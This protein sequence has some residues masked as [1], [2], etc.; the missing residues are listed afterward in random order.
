MASIRAVLSIA[1]TLALL[2][3]AASGLAGQSLADP[4]LPR[5]HV[6]ISA[7]GDFTS[8][9]QGYGEA[10]EGGE[11]LNSELLVPGLAGLETALSAFAGDSGP[12]GIE[13]GAQ[14]AFVSRSTVEVPLG[15]EVGIFD[16]LTV[17]A[18]L[19][20]VQTRVEAELSPGPAETGLGTNPALTNPGAVSGYLGALRDLG[21]QVEA[22][23]ESRCDADANS[24]GCQEAVAA[25]E[26]LANGRAGLRSAYGASP[27]FP[28]AGSAGAL[29]LEAW[30]ADLDAALTGLGVA[31]LGEIPPLPAA[32][33]TLEGY[34]DLTGPGGALAGTPLNPG[35]SLWTPGDISLS[36]ALRLVD[37]TTRRDSAGVPEVRISAAATAALRIPFGG[38][39]SLDIYG[40]S[41]LSRGQQDVEF[42]GWVGA[43]TPRLALRARGRYTLQQSNTLETRR[44]SAETALGSG[45][46]QVVVDPGEVLELEVEPAVRLAPALSLG[47]LWRYQRR[48]AG[49]TEV[50]ALQLDGSGGVASVPLAVDFLPGLG[51]LELPEWSTHEVGGTLTYH[52]VDIGERD[53]SGFEAFLRIVRSV[54][55]DRG[56]APARTRATMGLR[57]VRRLWGS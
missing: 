42:G 28:S 24:P 50:S 46:A 7:M 35:E 38:P 15:L 23:V 1:P 34:R 51:P 14:G 39:D 48:G 27:F 20:L 8:W 21:T 33:I 9:S 3:L 54:G 2:V 30:V 19:P 41:G 52:T 47:G 45:N 56:A 44:G 36:A 37:L 6:R 49:T 32:P 31:P 29:A 10:F 11:P 55:G 57:L 13:L 17:G 4:V 5:G 53:G 12:L 26:A 40:E 22:L 18:S 16:W 25:G 43:S